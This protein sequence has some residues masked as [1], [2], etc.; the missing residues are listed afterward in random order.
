MKFYICYPLIK[1]FLIA[2]VGEVTE[3]A[4]STIVSTY[5]ENEPQTIQQYLDDFNYDISLTGVAESKNIVT[6]RESKPQ[7]IQQIPE[8]LNFDTSL[9]DLMTL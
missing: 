1:F 8:D 9:E 7:T 6:Y 2:E 5:R 3:V 4:E